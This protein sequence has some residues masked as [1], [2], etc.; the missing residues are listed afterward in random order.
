MIEKLQAVPGSLEVCRFGMSCQRA[1][2]WYS[3]PAGRLVDLNPT[4]AL[5]FRGAE[6]DKIDCWRLHPPERDLRM[7]PP[8]DFLIF[9]DEI[10]MPFRPELKPGPGDREVFIDPLPADY[11]SDELQEFLAAFGEVEEDLVTSSKVL[12]AAILARQDRGY[13]ATSGYRVGGSTG[14][15]LEAM[16]APSLDDFDLVQCGKTLKAYAQRSDWRAAVKL[17]STLEAETLMDALEA[18]STKANVILYSTVVTCCERCHQ[19]TAALQLLRGAEKQ[20]IEA[21]TI[22]YNSGISACVKGSEW[23]GALQLLRGMQDKS[24]PASVISFNSALSAPSGRSW[25]LMQLLLAELRD[26]QLQATVVSYNS[27]ISA[28]VASWSLAL[29]LVAELHLKQL[30]PDLI[31]YNAAMDVIGSWRRAHMLRSSMAAFAQPDVVT[32]GAV[33]TG[34]RWERSLQQVQTER[35]ELNIVACNAAMAS[36][37]SLWLRASSLLTE[38]LALELQP[39]SRSQNILLSTLAWQD[40]LNF[41]RKAKGLGI[42]SDAITFNSILKICQPAWDT[43]LMALKEMQLLQIRSDLISYSSL[44][45]DEEENSTRG[46][47][48]A[49]ALVLVL[50]QKQLRLDA[51]AANSLLGAISDVGWQ[52]SLDILATHIHQSLRAD[53]VAMNEANV[54]IE[55]SLKWRRAFSFI[56]DQG[57]TGMIGGAP[58]LSLLLVSFNAA[59]AAT[60]GEGRWD[61]ALE[62]MMCLER[63]GASPDIITFNSAM[64]S[65]K[66]SEKWSRAVG[67][68]AAAAQRQLCPSL[69][70]FNA[71]ISACETRWR[72]G[73][74]MLPE[75]Q[76]SGA[77]NVIT[78]SS[79]ISTAGNRGTWQMVSDLYWSEMPLQRL[80]PSVLTT[81]A[82]LSSMSHSWKHVLELLLVACC[83]ENPTI[84]ALNY[85]TAV[86]STSLAGQLDYATRLL[87]ELEGLSSSQLRFAVEFCGTKRDFGGQIAGN[88][89]IAAQQTQGNLPLG[90]FGA[91]GRTALQLLAS[92]DA[93][94]LRHWTDLGPAENTVDRGSQLSKDDEDDEDD[95]EDEEEE[96][97]RTRQEEAEEEEKEEEKEEKEEDVVS[98]NT[99]VPLL[100]W[101]LAMALLG[102]VRGA[103]DVV[104]F[105]SL[106][107]SSWRKT[108]GKLEELAQQQLQ[109][110]LVTFNS[111]I[112]ACDLWR[113][114]Q[115]L[116]TMM[117]MQ[118]VQSDV[119]TQTSCIS[120]N[121]KTWRSSC[122]WLADFANRHVAGNLLTLNAC[123]SATGAT[124]ATSWPLSLALFKASTQ[125]RLQPD[126]ISH[127]AAISCNSDRWPAAMDIFHRMQQHAMR[128]S[129]IS[130][131]TFSGV[132]DRHQLWPHSLRIGLSLASPWRWA[133]QMPRLAETK[134]MRCSA[135]ISALSA[136]R[137][138]WQ[139]AACLVADLRRDGPI[140]TQ[141]NV[142]VYNSMVSACEKSHGWQMA[143]Q[144]MDPADLVSFNS[145]I[146]A[147]EKAEQWQEALGLL[148]ELPM[149]PDVVTCNAALSAC[150]K[151]RRWQRVLWMLQSFPL[152]DWTNT[153]CNAAIA[154]CEKGMAWRRAVTLLTEQFQ[155]FRLRCDE[156][157]YSSA[158]ASLSPFNWRLALK[159][160]A[161]MWQ[162]A[163]QP[164][165]VAYSAA[166]SICTRASRWQETLALIAEADLR[167]ITLDGA[168]LGDALEGT[169]ASPDASALLGRIQREG[170]S[171]LASLHQSF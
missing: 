139:R 4:K 93:K 127:N 152:M 79:I 7:S 95:E 151:R 126:V 39:A 83:E 138:G 154:A 35:H 68:L 41:L 21:D 125:W 9:L 167:R 76:R 145:S 77:A 158:L 23:Q 170:E 140:G 98:Y 106:A 57:S 91:V 102:G 30:Q 42:E 24:I 132:C 108:L 37:G 53:V 64:N 11:G 88:G 166:V 58:D 97:R 130:Y 12:G 33:M 70:T 87:V 153:S 129:S 105:N 18:S 6:C 80:Q 66:K 119:V 143:L 17:L 36:C 29:A 161:Q 128:P 141:P 85:C 137:E 63:H 20:S 43:A 34:N 1:G 86:S 103:W 82:L 142:I 171:W 163:L 55:K 28:S 54:A 110:D 38:A 109:P 65:C 157:S 25:R 165:L 134:L 32:L 101:R 89:G 144:I 5:C 27:A 22:L 99:V 71:L 3:H 48:T 13:R 46:W 14:S 67:L 81:S 92:L 122:Q 51:I 84:M 113:L 124:G 111:A 61:L 78:C 123:I 44:M 31:S 121:Q 69:I 114:S 104:T 136:I 59:A 100:P 50:Q 96:E 10:P 146:S 118:T 73:L 72:L 52:V 150:E 74:M 115:E 40:A 15:Q 116:V 47:S 62:V 169:D 75:V 90:R 159:F 156:V 120:G 148:A 60:G 8:G 2:C 112:C 133:L 147:C 94:S 168:T 107:L 26:T 149:S 16:A 49:M 162:R 117:E 160:L 155:D 45:G 135:A 56:L 164:G 19:W 131:N